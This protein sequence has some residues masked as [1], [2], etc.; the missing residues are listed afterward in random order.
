MVVD[1][2]TEI[3]IDGAQNELLYVDDLVQMSDIIEGHRDRFIKWN[4]AFERKDL[5]VNLGN[6]KV[7]VSSCITQDGLTISKVGTCGVC[8][9]RAKAKSVLCVQHG[10]WFHGRCA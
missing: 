10:E 8:S 6:T 5:K 1:V 3:A 9:L 4:E 2:D 7:V